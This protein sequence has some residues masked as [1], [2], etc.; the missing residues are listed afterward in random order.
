M[1]ETPQQQAPAPAVSGWVVPEPVVAGPAPGYAYVGFW[2]RAAAFFIDSF[3]LSIPTSIAVFVAF[4]G[5]MNAS[6]LR[7]LGDPNNFV[8]DPATGRL[9][10]D[11]ATLAAFNASIEGMMG[12]LLL[13]WLLI[14]ALQLIYFAG[15]W[16]W[17]GGTP[18]QLLLGMQVRRERDGARLSFAGPVHGGPAMSCL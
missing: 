9:M 10:P 15:F 5:T 11:P 13:V 6:M 17:R 14:L 3:I 18:G 8:R 4:A 16:A 1:E 7:A 2:R 12:G